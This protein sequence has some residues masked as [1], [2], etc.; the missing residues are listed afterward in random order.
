M[1]RDYWVY[2]S[3]IGAKP[4]VI[5]G[6]DKYQRPKRFDDSEPLRVSA[7]KCDNTT[8]CVWYVSPLWH[9][10]DPDKF[11]YALLGDLTSGTTR[12]AHFV[13]VP[14]NIICA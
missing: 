2:P 7:T 8:I 1:K 3:M 10:N 14:N 9:F 13:L 5:W 4:G 6:P 11:V 12:Q